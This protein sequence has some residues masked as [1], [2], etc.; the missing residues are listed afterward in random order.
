LLVVVESDLRGASPSGDDGEHL[1]VCGVT[2]STKEH[3][4]KSKSQGLQTLSFFMT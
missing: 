2:N 4:K 1:V 3:I